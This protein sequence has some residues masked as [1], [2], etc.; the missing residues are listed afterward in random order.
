MT[1]IHMTEVK[2]CKGDLCGSYKTTN[3]LAAA[4]I[5]VVAIGVVAYT[6]HLHL[7]RTAKRLSFL[8]SKQIF[9]ISNFINCKLV[10]TYLNNILNC[11]T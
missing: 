4:I 7:Q 2:I 10:Y 9:K 8:F 11:I 3:D 5:A 1:Q 6:Y